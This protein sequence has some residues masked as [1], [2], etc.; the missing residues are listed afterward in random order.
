MLNSIYTQDI[1]ICCIEHKKRG[2][3]ES[4]GIGGIAYG[5]VIFDKVLCVSFMRQTA[6]MVS[7]FC[8]IPDVI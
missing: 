5:V 1:L 3:E 2:S 7:C 8:Y 6:N 4:L